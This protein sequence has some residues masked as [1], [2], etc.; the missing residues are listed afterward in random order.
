MYEERHSHIGE[1]LSSYAIHT[2]LT[3]AKPITCTFTTALNEK[4]QLYL[5]D[6][7]YA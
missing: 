4:Y 2:S 1:R 6:I 5:Q 7:R 3:E